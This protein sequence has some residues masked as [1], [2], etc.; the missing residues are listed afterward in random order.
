MARPWKL[1]RCCGPG[2]LGPTMT[3]A[4]AI[5][6]GPN[7][8]SPRCYVRSVRLTDDAATSAN[9]LE[10][11]FESGADGALE[12]VYN[13]F[14]PMVFTLCRRSLGDSDAREA[15]QD[16]FVAAWRNRDRYDPKRGSLPAW[17]MSIARNKVI[18]VLRR[19]QRR[20]RLVTEARV[21][22]APDQDVPA[23]VDHVADQLLVADLLATL[24]SRS[25]Q[26]VELSFFA[27]L[28]LSEIA[29]RCELPLGTVK[30]DYRRSIEKLRR[31]LE[32]QDA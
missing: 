6:P 21:E 16:T 32:G 1:H 24:S 27:G 18:D 4:T 2:H 30:S 26:V 10:A 31:Q 11:L 8:R 7:V 12:A 20:P 3:T 5:P 28:S 13:R 22:S 29:T 14:G 23:A 25:R 19:E 9:E 15:T 17:L